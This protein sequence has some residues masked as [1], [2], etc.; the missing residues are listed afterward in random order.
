MHFVLRGLHGSAAIDDQSLAG[1]HARVAGQKRDHVGD[2]IRR[3]GPLERCD[4]QGGVN[5]VLMIFEPTGKDRPGANGV[6]AN[7]GGEGFGERVIFFANL[8]AYHYF[9]AQ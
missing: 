1:H 7:I 6:H 8:L 2:I 9:M 3:R 4:L 5:H